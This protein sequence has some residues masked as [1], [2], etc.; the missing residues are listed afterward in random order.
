MM[1]TFY[2]LSDQVVALAIVI[3]LIVG[4]LLADGFLTLAPIAETVILIPAAIAFIV[5]VNR[6]KHTAAFLTRM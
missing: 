2:S 3:E 1:H 4:L 5:A 6:R